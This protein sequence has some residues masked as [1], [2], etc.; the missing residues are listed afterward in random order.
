MRF[1]TD[2]HH[3]LALLEHRASR[4]CCDGAEDLLGQLTGAI[5]PA[6]EA[7]GGLG[8]IAAPVLGGASDVLPAAFDFSQGVDAASLFGPLAVDNSSAVPGLAQLLGGGAGLIGDTAG[9]FINNSGAGV[10]GLASL[11]NGGSALGLPQ[12]GGGGAVVPSGTGSIKAPTAPQIAGSSPSPSGVSGPAPWDAGTKIDNTLPAAAG[13]ATVGSG[14]S[15]AIA[16]PAAVAAAAPGAAPKADPGMLGGISNFLRQ[17]GPLLSLGALGASALMP[18]TQIPNMGAMTG[19]ANAASQTAQSLIPSVSTGKLPA[20]AEQ[21]VQNATKDAVTN[22]KAKYAGM[23]LS[24][25]SMEGQD[26]AAANE[27]AQAMRFQIADEL[28]KTGLNAAGLSD[29]MY[30]QLAQ[31]ILSQD[32]GLMDAIAGFANA[33]ALGGATAPR[34]T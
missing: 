32:S 10:S 33:M 29:Q 28:T 7:A 19:N 9:S 13:T 2:A 20:G 21:M 1:H 27:R 31:L 15:S 16:P 30:A 23:G 22:I 34:T 18:K 5:A 12:A 17:N 14:G 4:L 26:V 6:A 24:G 8:A 25:S 11:L 3:A